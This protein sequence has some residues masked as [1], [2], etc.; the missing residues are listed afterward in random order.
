MEIL[1]LQLHHAYFPDGLLK[2][3]SL[4]PSKSTLDFL[5]RYRVFVKSGDNKV[6]LVYIGTLSFD[7]FLSEFSNLM[8]GRPL[9]FEVKYQG[10]GFTV[11]TDIP[12]G[13]LEPLNFS[14]AKSS[15]NG[16]SGK[17]KELSFVY[18]KGPVAFDDTIL[19]IVIDPEYLRDDLLG[20]VNVYTLNIN[21][22]KTLWTYNVQNKG[23][24]RNSNLKIRSHKGKLFDQRSGLIT[25]NGEEFKVFEVGVVEMR[26]TYD[27][28]DK[29][30]L[31]ALMNTGEGK[32]TSITKNLISELGSPNIDDFVV[33]EIDGEKQACSDMFVYL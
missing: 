14:N 24:I 6:V 1:E 3:A 20:G 9:V 18:E 12:L 21:S 5:N 28:K 13:V 11:F 4:V 30:S 32:S 17:E 8:K 31:V 25:K 22:R 2:Y 23:K 7:L 19:K 29:F 27:L 33:K 26:L 15:I 16:F 10:S